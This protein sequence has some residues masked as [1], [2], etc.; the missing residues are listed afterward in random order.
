MCEGTHIGVP[1][2]VE[3]GY[4]FMWTQCDCSSLALQFLIAINF[5]SQTQE[6]ETSW[7]SSGRVKEKHVK[8]EGQLL[9]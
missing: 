6:S 5:Q 9:S 3:V 1:L 4:F 7:L 8:V 2:T